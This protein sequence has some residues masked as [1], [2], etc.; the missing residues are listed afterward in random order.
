MTSQQL[1]REVVVGLGYHDSNGYVDESIEPG[2]RGFV[3]NDLHQKCGVDAAYFNGSVPV[4][5]FVAAES[6]ED[7]LLVQRRLWNYGRL[8]VLIATTPTDAIVLSCNSQSTPAVPDA[9]VL[10]EAGAGEDL[11]RVLDDFSRFSVESGRLTKRYEKRLDKRHRVDAALLG[12]LKRIRERLVQAGVLESEIEPLLGRSIFV[13]YLEDREILRPEDLTSL[14]QPASLVSAL[15]EGWDAVVSFFDAMSDHFNGDVFRKDVLTRPIRTEALTVLRDFFQAT[16]PDSGQQSLWPYD[17][18]IIAPELISS[19]YEELLVEKQ[20]RDAAYYTPRRVV[21]MVL[22]ELLPTDWGTGPVQTILDP[23]CGSGIFLTESFRRLVYQRQ[24][25]G[26]PKNYQELSQLLV[27]TVFGIDLNQDAI[28]VTAFGLYLALLEHVDPRTIWLDVRLPDLIGS[29]LIVSDFFARNRLSDREFDLIVGNPPWKSRLS[30]PARRYIQEASEEI[31]DQQVAAAFVWR[32]NELLTE[33]GCAGFVLP[34]KTFLHNRSKTAD[35]FRLRFFSRLPVR[36]IID[37]SPLRKDLFGAK[38]PAALAIFGSSR[39]QAADESVLHVS[40]RRTPVAQIVDGIVIPQQNIQRI[41]RPLTQEDPSIWKRLLWGGS[42]D[43]EVVRHLRENFTTLAELAKQEGWSDGTGYQEAGGGQRDASHLADIQ[44][45]ATRDF[46]AMRQPLRMSAPVTATVMHFPRSIDI[47]RGPHV[48]MRKGFKDFPEAAF[49]SYDATFTDG[50]SS[51]SGD[52]SAEK[53]LKAVAAILN[54][55]VARYWFLMTA[56]SWGVEREQLQH[57]EWM[58][59]PVPLLSASQVETLGEVVTAAADEVPEDEWRPQLERTVHEAY[60][61]MPHERQVISDALEIRLSELRWGWTSE[62]Y[63]PPGE[64]HFAAYSA[65][66]K[67]YLDELEIGSWTATLAE[68]SEGFAMMTCRFD[69]RAD[70]IGDGINDGGAGDETADRI[71][72]VSH[73]IADRTGAHAARLSVATIVEPQALVLNEDSVHLVK[74]DRL[75]CWPISGA[76]RDAADIFSALLTG[77]VAD[78][79]ESNA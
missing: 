21:D 12:H 17:F 43:G 20:A 74:P 16:D 10:V 22:D 13:K 51:V 72:S 27:D 69:D 38:S 39:A 34:S 65:A 60:G 63:Q 53:H 79:Q 15:S 64:S 25:A 40:P 50:L 11:P 42:D 57:R 26:R 41:S 2:G 75:S 48:L 77:E 49:I 45:I 52:L 70:N 62:A 76:R 37:L 56:S 71:F 68:R 35:A 78:Q 46:R 5:A 9:A 54:S 47:F 31:P 33:D 44:Q 55:A 4:V 7:A 24:T 6:R 73:L 3:W 59:L 29:N 19:I 14:G 58:S 30:A 8:P 18:S 1:L 36:T 61:L 28:G 66:L 67:A 23:A 32:A